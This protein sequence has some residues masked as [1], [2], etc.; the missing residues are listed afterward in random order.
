MLASKIARWIIAVHILGVA[1]LTVL[2][3][4]ANKGLLFASADEAVHLK[5]LLI[6]ELWRGL[7][8]LELLVGA[9]LVDVDTA[10]GGLEGTHNAV[11]A[12]IGAQVAI[13]KRFEMVYIKHFSRQDRGQ[14]LSVEYVFDRTLT[15]CHVT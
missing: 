15:P 11:I 4:L 3:R 8:I 5:E 2:V 10:R 12:T 1:E 14:A 6:R 9:D 13:N 7:H